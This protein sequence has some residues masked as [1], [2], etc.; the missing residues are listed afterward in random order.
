MLWNAI[1]RTV[2]WS[3]DRGTWPYDAL[4]AGI[5]LFVFL[6]PTHWFNDKAQV[7]A[8]GHSGQVV[9]QQEEPSGLKSYRV[10]LHLLVNPPRTTE[11]ERR[12]HDVLQ[13]HVEG[14]RGKVFQVVRI[15][16]VTGEDGTVHSYDVWVK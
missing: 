16:P 7:T 6:S 2:F 5:V 14:L 10:D 9:L 11:L 15:E 1:K 8:P 13:K 12:A 3:Y 4:V